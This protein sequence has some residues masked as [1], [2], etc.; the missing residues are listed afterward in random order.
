MCLSIDGGL[1]LE[2]GPGGLEVALL[3]GVVQGGGPSVVGTGRVGMGVGQQVHR[4]R[5]VAVEYGFHQWGLLLPVLSAHNKGSVWISYSTD[6]REE[7]IPD[8]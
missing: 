4:Y 2:Q 5:S 7:N 8:D 3:R 1:G 6:K